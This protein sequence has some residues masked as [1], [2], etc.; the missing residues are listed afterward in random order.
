MEISVQQ[1]RAGDTKSFEKAYQHYHTKLYFYAFKHLQSAFL[2]EET[3]QLTFIKLWENRQK[4]SEN[5][6]LSMQVFRVAKS[7]MIDLLRKEHT[8][9]KHLLIPADDA[10]DLYV[11]TDTT[12]K[13]ELRRVNEIIEEMPQ[14][15][16]TVFKLS[17]F[18]DLSHKEI[19]EH[20]SISTKTVENQIGRA[21]RH[22]KDKIGFL[23]SVLV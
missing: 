12:Y 18:D 22:L 17:R 15:R 5:V 4:L 23:I 8:S 3:V 19:A 2:S 11:E 20:L 1:I 6:E 14:A 10:H 21:L 7:T 9:K 16:K 13:D